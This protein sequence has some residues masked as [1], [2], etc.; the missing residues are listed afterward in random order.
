MKSLLF[1]SLVFFIINNM[2]AIHLDSIKTRPTIEAIRVANPIQVDG[3]LTEQEWR[4]PGITD[5]TQRDPNEGAQPTHKT[6][7]W[8]A[9]DD[10][11]IYVAAR[12][13]DD[14]PDSIVSRIG[15][16]D[17]DMSSDWFGVC[18]DT[19]HDRRNG[20][21]FAAYPSGSIFDGIFFNDSWDDRT[22]DGVWDVATSIDDKG[23]TTEMKIPY[24]QL[25]F[26]KLDE[27]T[28]GINFVRGI[29]RYKEEVWY[30]MVPK[31]ESGF[32]SRFADLTGIKN[33][34]PPTRIE[35]LP[36]VVGKNKITNQIEKKN[37][38][39]DGSQT[40]GSIG[41]DI[42]LGL[43]SNLTLNATIN[44]DFGQVEVDPA[45]VNLSAFETY[46]EEKRPF[47]IDGSNYFNFGNGG[48]N[49]NV[50]FNWGNPDYFYSR[51]I[52]R[53]PEGGAQHDG[54]QNFPD[55]TTILG[56]A[57]LTGKITDGWSIGTMH[58]LTKR[59]Y[60]KIVDDDANRF[61]DVV[62]PFASY[63]VVRSL[64]EFD[65]GKQALGVLGTATLRDLNRPYLV[66]NF[67]RRAY[68]LGID[69]WTNLD[70][71]QQL[72]MT[73]WFSSTRI[74]G[75]PQRMIDIQRSSLHY[76]QRPDMKYTHVDS[77]A[78]HL[79]GYAGRIA[80]NN[81]KGNI[82][83]NAAMG[84]ITPGFESNDL[85]YL[86]RTNV[87]N[88]HI[89]VGYNWFDPDGTFR[90]KGF[91]VATFRNYDFDGNK[92]GE[93]YFL[94]TN[95][96]LMNYWSFS[97]TISYSPATF[98]PSSTRG[99][100]LMRNTRSYNGNLYASTDYRKQIVYE[101]DIGASRSESGGSWIGFN[102]SIEWKPT[103]NINLRLSTSISRDIT[104]AQWVPSDNIYIPAS[105]KYSNP[106]PDS[107]ASL[108]YG[109]RYIFAEFDQKEI[110]A[111]IRLDWTF[112]PK[113]S[114]QLYMQPLISVGHYHAFK[115]LTR[116]GIYAF[117]RYGDNSSSIYYNNDSETFLVDPDGTG[118]RNFEISNPDF[119]YKSLRLN[120]VLRWEF[121]PGSTAFFVW[122][123]SGEHSENPGDFK[124]GRDLGNLIQAPDHE[125]V[126]LVKVAYW[127]AL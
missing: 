110:S 7:V 23:W 92:F 94:F 48:A 35:I 21:F 88:G 126:F 108:T 10:A 96:Q 32:V 9:Y 39:Y 46:F 66:D 1:F 87:I 30:V 15:R 82:V 84:F 75:T 74:E 109:N 78:T 63:N 64:Y 73:G 127:I 71:D 49:N 85:G 50:N 123:R 22:W 11:A 24:S 4:R 36:Y 16:R 42:K 80:V 113:I 28:W 89:F 118:A 122:T 116:A 27:Y 117:N 76:F 59:E 17:A 57:K 14:H 106:V 104:M 43:G 56:A 3:R 40:K 81:Q 70:P 101:F 54:Y 45:V 12:M 18:L 100:P 69:G 91:R 25:R 120:T 97:S 52:G 79:S 124:F 20:F 103:S 19:Y 26:P 121:L 34:H 98:N 8:V 90:R 61:A 86:W 111:S 44:P 102:P 60:V 2:Q 33:I 125:D 65:K 6:E 83:F 47:F 112:T 77:T 41:A 105:H 29:D 93:G 62:E 51:R 55:A 99:G 67:N 5:F 115:E 68:A 72:V 119:N 31:K 58:A 38:F 95:A 53:Y 114:L 13:Y 107:T 37:P